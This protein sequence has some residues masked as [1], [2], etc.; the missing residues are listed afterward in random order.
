MRIISHRGNLF[1][2]NP[3]KENH[4]DYINFALDHGV[5]CEIDL[6]K[7]GDRLF[8]GHGAPQYEISVQFLNT[9][10]LW[11]H[12]KNTEALMWACSTKLN[13]FWHET[14]LATLTSHGYVWCFP[15]NYLSAGITVLTGNEI[16]VPEK[17]LGVCTD[18]P[19]NFIK[20]LTSHN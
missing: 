3:D 14:D 8:L 6:W 1:G 19:D 11:I 17:V 10:N 20:N 18:Y 5:E 12:I 16:K 9:P 4:P 7:V 13:Y 15:G 2:P